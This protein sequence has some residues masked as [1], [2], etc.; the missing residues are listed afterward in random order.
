MYSTEYKWC[1]LK[2]W[3]ANFGV[4]FKDPDCANG[5]YPSGLINIIY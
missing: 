5:L 2:K 4:G 1:I 3:L